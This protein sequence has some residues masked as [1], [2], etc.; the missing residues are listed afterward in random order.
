MSI[1]LDFLPATAFAFLLVFARVGAITMALPGIGDRTVPPQ[2][3]LVF[4]LSLSLV[5]LPL[6]QS[7]LPEL[8]GALTGVFAALITE[9]II[10]IAIGFVVRMIISVVQIAGVTIAFQVG[11]SFAQ[12]VDPTQGTQGS[13]VGNFLSVLAVA[14]I[15]ATDMHHLMLAAMYDSYTLFKPGQ[16]LPSGDFAEVAL[17]TVSASFRVGVQL[18]APFLVFGLIFYLGVGVLTRLIPQVQVFFLA[19]P[20]NITLG[21]I[22]LLLL[23]SSI[24]VWFLEYFTQALSPFLL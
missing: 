8:P 21:F 3:R 23:I 24:M 7:K 11:L 4:A 12:N 17:N 20:A 15:F 10:G 18:A 9:L 1:E 19:M 2:I 22:L 16:G 13:M 6:M 14:M 5:M